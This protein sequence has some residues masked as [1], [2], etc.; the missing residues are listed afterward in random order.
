VTTYPDGRRRILAK[1]PALAPDLE[2]DE[3]LKTCL[4]VAN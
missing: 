4:F 1:L 2:A 3:L